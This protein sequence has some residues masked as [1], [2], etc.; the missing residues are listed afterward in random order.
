MNIFKISYD[1]YEGEHQDILLGKDVGRDEFE[2]DLLEAKEFAEGLIGK[3]IP[4]GE[5]I[6]KGYRVDCLPEY[7]EQIIWF[8][9]T[10]AGYKECSYEQLREYHI[11]D[12]S[13]KKISIN[14][15]VQSTVRSEL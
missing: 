5:Y 8:L 14:V 11:D 6:G 15:S 10:K 4:T 3:E 13:P 9:T 2:K 7:F 1:W 12:I